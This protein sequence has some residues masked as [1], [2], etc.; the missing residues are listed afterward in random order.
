MAISYT[1]NGLDDCL[2]YGGRKPEV[3]INRCLK[4]KLN[5]TEAMFATAYDD[6]RDS[7]CMSLYRSEILECVIDV[8]NYVTESKMKLRDEIVRCEGDSDFDVVSNTSTWIKKRIS[9]YGKRRNYV[10]NNN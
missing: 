3:R 10:K 1:L 9:T 6:F 5:Q 2:K 8:Y 4:M 7:H